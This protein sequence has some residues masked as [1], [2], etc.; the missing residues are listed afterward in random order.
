MANKPYVVVEWNDT[1]TDA[2]GWMCAYN[3]VGHYC[4]GGTRMHPTVTKEE[5]IR[6]A[7]TM[8]REVIRKLWGLTLMLKVVAPPQVEIILMPE[9]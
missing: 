3:F 5:V 4:G 7:T 6:L 8:Q 1:E 2:K 9:V